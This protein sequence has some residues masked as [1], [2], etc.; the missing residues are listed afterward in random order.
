MSRMNITNIF[1]LH[2]P[3]GNF[4]WVFEMATERAYLPLLRTLEHYE[5]FPFGIHISGPLW[6]YFT[7][8]VPD[9]FELISKMVARGQAELMGG[10][11]YEPILA[12]IPHRDALDQL[13]WMADFLEDH[14]GVRPEGAWLTERI[15]EPH[16]P[17][18]L[19]RASVRYTAADDYHFKAVG[20]TGEKLFGYY[21]T[22]D[23]GQTV[24]IFP[25]S[26]RLRYLI[27]FAEPRE[28]INYLGQC[29]DDSGRRLLVFGDDGEKFG[30]WPGTYKWVWEEKWFE[31]FVETL[32]ANRDW[33][34]IIRPSDAL[35]HLPPLGR[36]YLPTGSYFEM[37]EWTLPAVLS[38]QFAEVVEHFKDSGE[39]GQL[40]PF[41]KGGFW[42]NF[43]TKYDES[44]WMHKR[45]LFASG[46]V[47]SDV[48]NLPEDEQEAVERSLFRSQ[49]NCAYWHGVFGG[50]YLPHLRKGVWDNI[51]AAEKALKLPQ[52]HIED[53]D[54]DAHK[55]ILLSNG[56]L[57]LWLKPSYGGMIAEL[58]LVD[59]DGV[60]PINL[61]DTLS[62]HPE[63]YHRRVKDV[64]REKDDN[65]HRSIHDISAVKEDGLEQ[66]L[67][68]D[69]YTRRFAQ[70]HILPL[71]TKMDAFEDTSY[72]EWGDFIKEPYKVEPLQDKAGVILRREGGLWRDGKKSSLIIQKRIELDASDAAFTVSYTVENPADSGALP[73]EFLFAVE[74]NLSLGSPD[75]PKRYFLFP[76]ETLN[77]VKPAGNI[78][79]AEIDGYKYYD[80]ENRFELSCRADSD[81]L[82]MM[83]IYTVSQSENGFERVY[84]GTTLVHL[85]RLHLESG[86]QFTRKLT[87]WFTPFREE[88]R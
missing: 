76:H 44:N 11:F 88:K 22:E 54:C 3:V 9:V 28:T 8:K 15:W 49:C 26:E 61:V 81:G 37:S 82:W 18:I 32:L 30:L 25:I 5:E 53:I 6:E 62:R 4:D 45:M 56:K 42:R 17:A 39:F 65:E 1:H 68:Y 51:L 47:S 13:E 29:S 69:W 87:F 41:L 12:V 27:P 64:T 50:L 84:Q 73:L 7:E 77:K 46:R 14:F 67:H 86:E 38:A 83:P 48:K 40:Q 31:R 63:G 19:N 24:A 70:E 66:L 55:E 58:D 75:D 34:D 35:A 59:V 72:T 78:Q 43:L 10:G 80:L 36:V 79:L 52:M 60:K 2:Q 20:I 74:T 16:L 57:R 85:W 21:I 71:D 33:M 23:E